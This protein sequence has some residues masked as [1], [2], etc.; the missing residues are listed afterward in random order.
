LAGV[1]L[2]AG[3]ATKSLGA[4]VT[5]KMAG[6]LP[7]NHYIVREGTRYWMDLVDKKTANKVH[8]EYYPAEQLGKDVMALAQAGAIDIAEEPLAYVGDRMPLTGVVELPGMFDT[9]CQGT[10][11]YNAVAQPGTALYKSDY[12]PNKVH[13]LLSYTTAPYRLL[14]SRKPVKSPDDFKGMKLR[15]N[16]GAMELMANELGAVSVRMSAL[17]IYQS[18]SRGTLDGVFYSLQSV[19]PYDL[20]TVAKYV[21]TGVSFGSAVTAL[22]ISDSSWQ[23]LSPDVQKAMLEA[24]EE[25]AKHFCEYADA[26]EQSEQASLA[27]NG[28]TMLTLKGADRDALVARMRP[29]IDEWARKQEAQNRPGSEV[30]KAFEAAAGE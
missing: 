27:K 3:G 28:L 14:T 15:T 9:S 29:A 30:V 17:D 4:D 23:R 13:R 25:T 24:G 2:A 21:T 16:G 7:A 26:N 10:A 1:V 12:E 22:L 6:V 19:R 11:A 18:F 20:Q 5:L 8:F